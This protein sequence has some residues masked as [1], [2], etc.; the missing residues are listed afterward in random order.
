MKPGAGKTQSFKDCPECP[1]MVVLPAGSFV[2]GSPGTEAARTR[3][4]GPQRQVTIPR[5]F[6]VGKFEVTFAASDAC[7]AAGGCSHRPDDQGWGRNQQPAIYLSWIDIVGQYL[8]WLRQTTGKSYRL[9]S[10]A[11]WEYA[12]RAGTT[13]PFRR[14]ARL[15][16]TKPTLPVSSQRPSVRSVPMRLGSTT[17]TGISRSGSRIATKTAMLVRRLTVQPPRPQTAV[18]VSCVMDPSVATLLI[19]T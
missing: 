3:S 2:M 15:C 13:T 5:P 17:C 12:A 11:E 8:P 19:S 10:E 9:L 4:E 1:E 18:F 16:R 7:V 6:A 14:A